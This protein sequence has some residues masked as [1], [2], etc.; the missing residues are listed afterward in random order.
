[1]CN[2]K[3]EKQ[4]HSYEVQITSITDEK[5]YTTKS[6]YALTHIS[7]ELPLNCN[8]LVFITKTDI[9]ET[10]SMAAIWCWDGFNG[11]NVSYGKWERLHSLLIQVPPAVVSAG[12]APKCVYVFKVGP[13]LT[14]T[15]TFFLISITGCF[16]DTTGKLTRH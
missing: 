8:F 3:Q 7:S 6:S 5:H 16:V 15:G 11:F 10:A 4:V 2:V 12:N 1:M 13:E 14:H 9:T